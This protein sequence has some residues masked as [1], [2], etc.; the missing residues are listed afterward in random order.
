MIWKTEGRSAMWTNDGPSLYLDAK[1]QAVVK[2]GDPRA[3]F[4]LVASGGQLS[5]DE[6]RKWGLLDDQKAKDRPPN[7]AKDSPPNKAKG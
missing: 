6:A 5:E 7:K 3:S 1:Q 2:D 4:L